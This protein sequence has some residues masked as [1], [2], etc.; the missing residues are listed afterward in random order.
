MQNPFKF[1]DHINLVGILN[2][3]NL[4]IFRDVSKCDSDVSKRG[5]A[6]KV[7]NTIFPNSMMQHRSWESHL[8]RLADFLE[9]GNNVL[10][11]FKLSFA[12]GWVQF[13]LFSVPM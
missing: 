11:N 7:K 1:Y 8:R 4:Y 10:L 12:Q 13:S 6:V 2:L 3:C 9:H 5:L